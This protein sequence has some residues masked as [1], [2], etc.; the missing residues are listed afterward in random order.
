MIGITG[1]SL[2]INDISLIPIT[3]QQTACL[4][5][6]AMGFTHKQ[7]AQ[8]MCL[9]QKT[10]EHYLNA[11]KLKLNCKTRAE[12]ISQAIERGLVGLF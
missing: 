7:I 8:K 6:L 10:V 9:A 11:V 5:Y 3:K 12:L 1:F 4:K 2:K